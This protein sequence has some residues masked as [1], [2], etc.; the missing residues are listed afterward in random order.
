MKK[1][2]L[3]S[4]IV[5]LLFGC[6]NVVYAQPTQLASLEGRAKPNNAL[7]RQYT[8]GESIYYF[9]DDTAH[10]FVLQNEAVP[11]DAILAPFPSFLEVHDFEIYQD[12]MYFC[13]KY[14][15]G[16]TPYGLV[17]FVNVPELFNSNG[18]YNLSIVDYLTFDYEP[19]NAH[20]TSCNRMDVF[21]DDI[22]IVHMAIVGEIAHTYDLGTSNST[23]A[24]IWFDGS[25]WMGSVMYHKDDLYKATDI[26]CTDDAVVVSA[27]DENH[28]G[29][30]ILVY[31]KIERFPT[32][33]VYPYAIHVVD[34]QLIGDNVLV[35]RLSANDVVV[36]NHFYDSGTNEYGTAIHF[37]QEVIN[38]PSIGSLQS[39]HIIH[40]M[41]NAP[42]IDFRYNK[43]EDRLLLLHNIDYN[44][45]G[46][47]ARTFFSFSGYGLS[48]ANVEVWFRQNDDIEMMSIDNRYIYSRLTVG[49]VFE[50]TAEPLMVLK[51]SPLLGCYDFVP[52]SCVPIFSTFYPDTLDDS[53][54]DFLHPN[55]SLYS[56]IQDNHIN[57]ICE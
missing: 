6:A 19:T 46:V 8:I 24:D 55:I 54:L 10:Y 15:N 28:K 26:T 13:G 20:M 21:E 48:V 37:I 49:G 3:L 56:N 44:Q 17:G 4:S 38:L 42:Q 50:P 22:G 41:P 1:H 33:P 36:T 39:N 51:D 12:V 35:E 34:P 47:P 14:P 27:Y 30:V 9:E 53:Y 31:K 23:F 18:P 5:V 7:S 45:P 11:D 52:D 57:P 2:Y 43:E 25:D 29:P 40:G 32:V 16:G